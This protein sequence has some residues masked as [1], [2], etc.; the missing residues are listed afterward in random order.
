MGLDVDTPDPPT[1]RDPQY[2]GDYDSVDEGHL[3]DEVG[4][5]ARRDDLASFLENGAWEQAFGEWADHTMLGEDEFELARELDLLEALDFYWNPAAE[6]VGYR[7]P[8][9]PPRDALPEGYRE[10][11]D[12]GDLEGIEEELEELARTVTEVLEAGYVDSDGG[13]FG[14]YDDEDEGFEE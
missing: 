1:L 9:V 6:D 2:P 13:E 12:A 5:D 3:D 8:S 11:F 4:D 10:A 7:A 14:F